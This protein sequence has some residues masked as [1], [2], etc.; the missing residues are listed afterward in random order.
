ME[1]FVPVDLHVFVPLTSSS[2]HGPSHLNNVDFLGGGVIP[3][4]AAARRT[5]NSV[6]RFAVDALPRERDTYVF[7]WGFASAQYS[8]NAVVSDVRVR[9]ESQPAVKRVLGYCLRLARYRVHPSCWYV[10]PTLA[11]RVM[12]LRQRCAPRD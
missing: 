5:V 10:F 8:Q 3:G 4:K 11:G 1:L 9:W 2:V 7:G 6:I 12:A